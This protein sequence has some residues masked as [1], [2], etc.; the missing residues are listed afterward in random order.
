MI[1]GAT[2]I[3]TWYVYQHF[4]FDFPFHEIY[5]R[6]LFFTLGRMYHTLW[7]QV[8]IMYQMRMIPG[9]YCIAVCLFVSGWWYHTNV[10]PVDAHVWRQ[11]HLSAVARCSYKTENK[12]TKCLMFFISTFIFFRHFYFPAQLVGG[13]TR[14][15][16]LDESWSQ[17][18]SLPPP[19]A[20]LQFESR[21][22]LS[23]PT[24]RRF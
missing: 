15:D 12:Q 3:R 17:V 21:I 11:L 2:Y 4:L 22:G 8:R 10:P 5:R 20:C 6:L 14:N 16:L 24:A 18:S 7:Y 1:S 13:F 19:G 9:T 23:T